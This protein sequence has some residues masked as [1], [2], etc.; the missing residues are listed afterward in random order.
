MKAFAS[1][2]SGNYDFKITESG[3]Q[4]EAICQDNWLDSTTIL[5]DIPDPR[6]GHNAVW[7]GTEMIVWGGGFNSGGRY[8]P[9]TNSWIPLSREIGVP[10]ARTGS[11]AVWT[12]TEMIIWGGWDGSAALNSGGRYNPSTDSWTETD[13][14]ESDCPEARYNHVAVWSGTQMLVWGGE[15]TAGALLDTGGIFDPAGVDPD[16]WKPITTSG[17]PTI[18]R[19]ATSVFMGG[20]LIVWGGSTVGD[21]VLNTG[22]IYDPAVDSWTPTDTSDI[23]CPAARRFHTA[24]A[25][26]TE[27]IIWGGEGTANIPLNTG[28]K[29][30]PAGNSWIAMTTANA[31]SARRYHTAV[32][33]ASDMI[34][35]GGED[36]NNSFNNGASYNL[37]G[38]NWTATPTANAPTARYQHTAVWT[39]T[40]MIVWGGY[41]PTNSGGRYNPSTGW[42]AT[43]L[44]TNI[45]AGRQYHTAVWT[46][47]EMIVWGGESLGPTLQLNTGGRYTPA[48]DSWTATTTDSPC[49]VGRRYHTAVWTGTDMIVWGGNYYDGSEHY[50][51]S[52][53]LYNV[54][55][56]N[57][58]ATSLTSAPVARQLHS[59]VWTGAEMIIWGGH[60]SSAYLNSGGRYAPLTAVWTATPTTT[61]VPAIR[62][63]HTAVWSGTRMFVWGGFNGGSVLNTGSIYNPA[64]AG[65]TVDPYW[66]AMPTTGAPSARR[67]HSAVWA[68]QID[69]M[70][71]WGGGGAGIYSTGGMLS[72]SN[73][74]KAWGWVATENTVPP[75]PTARKQHSAIWT[76]QEMIV[77]GGL[78]ANGAALD[79]GGRLNVNLTT[80]FWTALSK[81]N[82]Y[83]TPRYIHTA[84][85]DQPTGS[86][87]KKMTVWGGS[88]AYSSGGIYEPPPQIVGYY[89]TC[90]G[91]YVT[92]KAAAYSSY[93][94]L[95]DGVETGNRTGS[96]STE[97]GGGDSTVTNATAGVRFYISDEGKHIIIDGQECHVK[98]FMNP[99]TVI[100]D[101]EIDKADV[102]WTIYDTYQTYEATQTGDYNVRVN[103]TCEGVPHHV[104][105]W[106]L[107]AP[108][109]TGSTTGCVNPGVV[110]DAGATYATYQWIEDGIDISG[111][112]S[113]TYTAKTVGTHNYT[114]RVT[115]NHSRVTC[116]GT[117]PVPFSLTVYAN[118]VPVISGVLEG[119]CTTRLRTQFS[120]SRSGTCEVVPGG[121]D[122]TVTN[123]TGG[124]SFYPSDVGKTITIDGVDYLVKTYLN[125]STITI[126]EEITRS[127]VGWNI[128]ELLDT[129]TKNGICDVVAAGGDSTV[130]NTTA[131]VYFYAD[132]VGR[133][134]TI[135]GLD[136][137][138]KTYVNQ[139]TI[140]IE[141]EIAKSGVAWSMAAPLVPAP[142]FQWKLGTTVVGTGN[143]YLARVNGSYTVVVIDNHGCS[144]TSAAYVVSNYPVPTI[145]GSANG[146]VGFETQLSTGSF[147]SY[148]WYK[149]TIAISGAT[150]QVYNAVESGSYT[151]QVTNAAG[152]SGMSVP[153]VVTFYSLPTPVVTGNPPGGDPPGS[154]QVCFT[155]LSTTTFSSYQW[156]RNG[157][158]ISGATAVTY[159]AEVS[160]DYTVR[161][162]DSHGCVGTS[163]PYTVSIFPP[164]ETPVVLGPSSGCAETGALLNTGTYASYQWYVN[165]TLITG[166]TNQTYLTTESGFNYYTVS[167]TDTNGCAAASSVGLWVNLDPPKPDVYTAQDNYWITD[168][169]VF[170]LAESGTTLFLGGDFTYVGPYTGSG[171]VVDSTTGARG[172]DWPKINGIVYATAPDGSGGFYFGGSFTKVG[173]YTR[174]NLAHLKADKSVDQDFAPAV[175]GTVW[176][177]MVQG[178]TLYAGGEFTTINTLTRNRLASFDAVT[179][180]VTG[181]SPNI[182]GNV[183][184]LSY[185]NSGT[186]NPSIYIGG[187]FTSVAGVTYNRLAAID[188]V[189]GLA[190]SWNPNIGGIVRALA[191]SGTKLFV[192]GEFTLASSTTRNRIASYDLVTG[193]LISTWNPNANG[194]V[195]SIDVY[196][197]TVYIGGAFTT[198]TNS[199]TVRNRMAALNA[200]ATAA[201]YATGWDPSITGATGAAVYALKVSADGTTVF[202]GGFFN[203]VKGIVA[204]NNLASVDASGGNPTAFDPVGGGTVRAL[205]LY[206]TSLAVG[207]DFKSVNGALRNHLASIDMT[208]GQATSWDPNLLGGT[209]TPSVY[210]M[211]VDGGRLYVGGNFTTVGGTTRN[212][213]AAFDITTGALNSWDGN[214]GGIV[215]KLL[216]SGTTLYVGGEFTMIGS[217]SQVTRNRLAA[218][219]LVTGSLSTTFNPNMGGNVYALAVSGTTLYVGGAFTTAN[220]TGNTRNRICAMDKDSG[221]I[222]TWNPNMGGIVRTIVVTP[223]LVYAGGEFTSGGGQT[224]NRLAA[225]NVSDGTATAWNPNMGGIVYA[226]SLSNDGAYLYAGGV[227]TTAGG[228]TYNRLAALDTT[229][230]LPSGD[231]A[232]DSSAQVNA[233]LQKSNVMF[234]G[235]NFATLRGIP[236]SCYGAAQLIGNQCG[237]GG[238]TLSTDTFA[239]YQWYKDGS[240]IDGA[241]SRSYTASG[242]GL[243][244][245]R[246]TRTGGCIGVS[247]EIRLWNSNSTAPVI[248]GIDN[249]DGTC[250]VHVNFTAGVPAV[251]H[252][253]YVDG[254][255]AQA[256]IATGFT[257]IPG[258][259]SSHSY[260]VRAV[261][262]PCWIDSASVSQSDMDCAGGGCT[263]PTAMIVETVTAGSIKWT[264]IAGADYY[265]VVRAVRADLASYNFGC[266]AGS[267]GITAGATG[268]DISSHDPSGETGRCY[269]YIVQGYDC[270]DP[271]EYLSPAGDGVVGR[272]LATTTCDGD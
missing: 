209:G 20:K 195:Y 153:K 68:P 43:S 263:A 213:L 134:I 231:W 105:I 180:Q 193:L 197:D 18:R 56:G 258:D 158:D 255:L 36:G 69:S 124:I 114:V 71:I 34:V 6:Y 42:A 269:Y 238:I 174:Q 15:N 207:G 41:W 244:K 272:T 249:F 121:G 31:P 266:F 112:T 131:G 48:T 186:G 261:N 194:I 260:V 97:S 172:T 127:G 47:T 137:L 16:K 5:E 1:G 130:T 199:G 50:L 262:G 169:N 117:S 154:Q 35:W 200:N 8:N 102:V 110:L 175:N 242:P 168:S 145:T 268:A 132:D 251:Q 58:T 188:A 159:K 162:T 12:G 271:D 178:T 94:W 26:A 177:L 88:G 51:N 54:A 87:G 248:T 149:D 106:A 13:T 113:K 103:G 65:T 11:T 204:R 245:V 150:D 89:E 220:G 57:W 147:A 118:P 230:G 192:G 9:A 259:S 187:A 61:G 148:Q 228:L 208:T 237:V 205:A 250:G 253:L 90:D 39:G 83:P 66:V 98:T 164:P 170:S 93:Q 202:A 183:Y 92:L 86:V 136:Y 120:T 198:I 7:T 59:A 62:Q 111:A 91:E 99:T 144:G 82:G 146:C 151:V 165:G 156:A 236:R 85:W 252:D 215:R 128:S 14:A 166:A 184:A 201:P 161:V 55:T 160:G 53:G 73:I 122:S 79:D 96:C 25:T 212:R 181:W 182:G 247:G 171:P 264:D 125:D 38:G 210:S 46:G 246:V 52:G 30:D 214:S 108:V 135:D 109:I 155:N 223:T 119:P 17:A 234:I 21:V 27:M 100:I 29:Y 222:T 141:E 224:R 239:T 254:M 190:T 32:L 3:P 241:T 227:F 33:T 22:G 4:P 60:S 78:D 217:P 81:D 206:S 185:Y 229:T 70:I 211:V 49:P 240:V 142:T 163:V 191:V 225:L 116:T 257:Y 77:F 107:P 95:K 24:V 129:V 256:G 101:E 140:T 67:W 63:E 23:D 233:L 179:G 216:V 167:V 138:V 2:A 84:V 40:E 126:D 267:Y 265:R 143:T 74:A 133:T 10:S 203:T 37:S 270:Q 196:G 176:A 218:F 139:T 219:D 28:A 80:S 72:Y 235:G 45:P 64:A 173:S 157:E 226:L 152:C 189:T 115:D 75:C 44:G 76:G 123:T 104:E 243:Y 232:P 221:V 19:Y